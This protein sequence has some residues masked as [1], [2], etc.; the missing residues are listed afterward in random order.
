MKRIGDLSQPW[1][2]P[3]TLVKVFAKRR[4]AQALRRA[5]GRLKLAQR[6]LR[7]AEKV[8]KALQR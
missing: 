8:A 7:D 1:R 5:K 4:A 2:C 3:P 6:E